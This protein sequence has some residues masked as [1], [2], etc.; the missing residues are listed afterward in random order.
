MCKC[1]DVE[2]GSYD[3]QITINNWW[4]DNPISIDKCIVD[5]IKSIWEHKIQTTGCCCGHNKLPKMIN[6]IPE[7][8]HKMIELNYEY[9]I[10]EHGVICYIPKSVK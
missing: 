7:H 8:H 1:K 3:N 9:I 10:N 6:V 2:I 5:E 4:N